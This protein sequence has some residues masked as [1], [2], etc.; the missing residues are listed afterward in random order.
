MFGMNKKEMQ[1]AIR[2]GLEGT[3]LVMPVDALT[4]AVT[5]KTPERLAFRGA[6]AAG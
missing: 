3:A 5:Q 6:G 2:K 4:D 1:E